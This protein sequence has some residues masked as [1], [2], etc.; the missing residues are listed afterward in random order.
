MTD[1]AD[2]EKRAAE[3]SLDVP[4]KASAKKLEEM[5]TAAEAEAAKPA[6]PT[7]EEVEQLKAQLVALEQKTAELSA[8]LSEKTELL[9]LTEAELAEKVS[10]LAAIGAKPVAVD[11][12]GDVDC[13]A[14]TLI[15]SDGVDYVRGDRLILSPGDFESLHASG[16]VAP[17]GEPDEAQ[18]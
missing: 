18:A 1:R 16:A 5:I 2:L 8:A 11:V 13:V 14:L 15:T 4:A 12:D 10:A 7:P 3:L 17:L 9:T 6:G